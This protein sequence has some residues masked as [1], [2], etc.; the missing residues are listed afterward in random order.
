MKIILLLFLAFNHNIM[1]VLAHE[2]TPIRMENNGALVGLPEK[3]SPASFDSSGLILDV[4][5]KIISI[6]DCVTR[7]FAGDR[8]PT[9][10]FTASWYHDS[11]LLP[12]YISLVVSSE[13]NQSYIQILFNLETLEIFEINKIQEDVSVDGVSYSLYFNAQEISENCKEEISNSITKK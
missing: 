9:F 12:Y 10:T 3:Y 7:Y 6:P 11:E 5:N 2:D 13:Q 1:N 4:G 8:S